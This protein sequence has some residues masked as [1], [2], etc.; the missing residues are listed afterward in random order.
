MTWRALI[1]IVGMTA[2]GGQ[3]FAQ[4]CPARPP[5]RAATRIINGDKASIKNWPGMV[6]LRFVLPAGGDIKHVY[7][8]GGTLIDKNWVLTAAHCLSDGKDQ[9]FVRNVPGKG[10]ILPDDFTVDGP[11]GLIDAKNAK[12][13][14]LI[15]PEN[16]AQFDGAVRTPSAIVVHEGWNGRWNEFKH[17]IALIKLNAPAPGPTMAVSLAADQETGDGSMW[18]AGFGLIGNGFSPAKNGRTT[19]DTDNGLVKL[20]ASV[21]GAKALA[22]SDLLQEVM[23]PARP[24]KECSNPALTRKLSEQDGQKQICAGVSEQDVRKRKDSCN[25]DSGGPMVRTGPD[26]CPVLM[27][28]VSYGPNECGSQDAWGVYTR[29]AGY[30]DW[31]AR[32]AQGAALVAGK[33]S[34]SSEAAAEL[35]AAMKFGRQTGLR[36]LVAEARAG[37]PPDAKGVVVEMT[38]PTAAKIGEL[39]TLKITPRGVS[40]YL[41]VADVDS[42]GTITWLLPNQWEPDPRQVK[43]GQTIT[44]GGMDT[45]DFQF[46]VGPPVGT[47]TVYAIIAPD[48]TLFTRL[49]LASRARTRGIVV[50]AKGTEAAVMSDTAAST[51]SRAMS[52]DKPV[53]GFGALRYTV[54]E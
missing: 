15:G 38:Q 25:G 53:L 14:I 24:A 9:A 39:R 3:A 12:L 54:A 4:T 41:A 6:A 33:P 42:A 31:I 34:V 30:S 47:N 36:G 23:L 10:W 27:G 13:E 2:V 26:G 52:A 8:C 21:R 22:G 49:Q 7:T 51:L 16:L 20:F 48:K 11:D 46:R 18:V 17:D 45:A 28:L 40:G 44:V 5:E 37:G 19:G 29:V 35:L 43:D 50:E 32:N 1:A